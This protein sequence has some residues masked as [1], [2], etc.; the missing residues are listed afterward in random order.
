MCYYY[1]LANGWTR[2]IVTVNKQRVAAL[3]RRAPWI[4]A[5]GQM[6]YRRWQPWM[7][8][9]VV[10]AILND[11]CQVLLVEHVFHP[12]FPWGFPGGWM[13]RR[14]DPEDTIRRE[15]LEET[16]LSIEVLKPLVVMTATYV[17]N[18]LDIA[19]LCYAPDTR[20]VRL[21]NELLAYRWCQ[22]EALVDV[23]LSLFHHH[24]ACAAL[25]E[26]RAG[27]FARKIGG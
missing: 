20:G 6:V 4:G 23:R 14:E 17:H 2:F 19:Y 21:S 18:H 26:I 24:V 16:G 11:Q 7:T 27:A 3:L 12:K 22:P 9:G 25:D 5:L 8:A 1:P 10:G 13:S 15:A